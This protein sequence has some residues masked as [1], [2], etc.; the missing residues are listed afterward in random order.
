MFNPS[1]YF[2]PNPFV[3]FLDL[4][5]NASQAYSFRK[6]RAGYTGFCIRVQRS[7]DS[8]QL[9]IGFVNN[10]L[11]IVTLLLFIGMN[12]G[13]IIIAYDQS[14]NARNLT[15]SVY[16]RIV[17]SGNLVLFNNKVS[18]EIT[19]QNIS[20]TS[21]TPYSLNEHSIF[22][23]NN[24]KTIYS[25]SGI[26]RNIPST[27]YGVQYPSGNSTTWRSSRIA[28]LNMV[29]RASN[30]RASRSTVKATPTGLYLT[31]WNYDGNIASTLKEN[32]ITQTLASI[33]SGWGTGVLG[34]LGGFNGSH[35]L[36]DFVELIVYPTDKTADSSAMNTLIQ[37]YYSL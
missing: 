22:S 12:N 23:V 13:Y 11:D 27:G 15:G 34:N 6:L 21:F 8:A 17:N 1:Y 35:A 2:R 26:Y 3:G 32:N 16:F 25:F 31:N 33:V 9:D 30:T 28:H 20:T 36:Q 5:P 18:A 7:S 10:Y 14:G 37:D 29:E 19:S 4:Y 24:I